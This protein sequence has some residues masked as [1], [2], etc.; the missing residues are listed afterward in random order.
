MTLI[1]HLGK[2]IDGFDS[3]YGGYGIGEKKLEGRMSHVMSGK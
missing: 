2:H 1:R 3:V